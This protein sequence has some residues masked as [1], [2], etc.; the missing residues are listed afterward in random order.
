M[1]GQSENKKHCQNEQ[2]FISQF[3]GFQIPRITSKALFINYRCLEIGMMTA[4]PPNSVMAL[5]AEIE[6]SCARTSSFLVNF[7]FPKILTPLDP[8]RKP[9]FIV[10][11]RG[12]ATSLPL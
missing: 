7:P 5:R 10:I 12:V 9:L 8:V 4:L 3:L 11:R 1:G 2:D 6:K